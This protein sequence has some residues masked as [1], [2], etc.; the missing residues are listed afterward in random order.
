MSHSALPSP[1]PLPGEIIDDKWRVE[2]ILGEGGMGAVALAWDLVLHTPVAIKFMNPQFLTFPGADAR[3]VNEGRASALIKSDH[4]VPVTVA[5]KTAN[6]TPF[7]V[8]EALDGI[9]LADLVARDGRPGLPVERA[10]HFVLQVLRALQAAHAI[11]II[12]RDMKPSNCFVVTKDGEED[13]VKILDFGISKVQKPGSASLTQTNSALGTP[14]YMSPEQARSPRDVDARSDLYSVGVILYELFTGQT[15]FFSES[16]EFTEILFKLFTA[17]PPPVKSRRP[18]LPDELAAAVHKAL[19]REVDNRF[20]S[21]LDMAE[22]IAPFA[23]ERSRHVLTRMRAFRAPNK[24]S[25]APPE[26]LPQSMVAFSQIPQRQ[27]TDVMAHRPTTDVMKGP[28]VT[29][30]LAR[31][32]AGA[33]DLARSPAPRI[34]AANAAI[35]DQTG[36]SSQS[37]LSASPAALEARARPD[38][39]SA[40]TQY[41]SSVTPRTPPPRAYVPGA[42][43]DLSNA[44]DTSALEA[45]AAGDRAPVKR[46]P[47]IY[48][49]PVVA[50]VI[51]AG[52][53]FGIVGTNKK[54]GGTPPPPSAIV[55]APDNTTAP[56]TTTGLVPSAEPSAKLAV[57]PS[58][59]AS[60]SASASASGIVK[61]T[62]PRP[63]ATATIRTGPPTGTSVLDTTMKQ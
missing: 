14:L 18:D 2:K 15:P 59:S 17:D 27:Q 21:A 40:R 52:A 38:E 1:Y 33:P 36:A 49:L 57:T 5:G 10:V 13:F 24:P 12:H 9:D 6:G 29:E 41:D 61:I 48:A 11:G 43:T 35:A 46:S 62:L 60:A 47:M 56:P 7:L 3:F 8:M 53:V 32:P 44:R 39:A 51:G 16:G 20:S 28:P 54:G 30:M 19:A 26:D 37:R 25:I 58:P 22:A 42:S 23:S 63:S 45:A 31:S 55:V 34:A 50:L 4:V